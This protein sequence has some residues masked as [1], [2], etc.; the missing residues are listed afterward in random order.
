MVNKYAHLTGGADQNCLALVRLL[1]ERGHDVAMLSTASPDN[2]IRDGKFIDLRVT[3]STR[4][5]LTTARRLDVAV[6]AL[7][8]PDAA[9]AMGDLIAG[10]EPD[11]VHTHK[12]YPQISVAPIVIA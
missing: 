8:N 11:V 2:V 6:R 1:A 5:S 4:R 7:W 9:R 3:H 10:F 12:L